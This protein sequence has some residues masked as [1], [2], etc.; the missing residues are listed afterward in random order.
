MY[1]SLLFTHVLYGSYIYIVEGKRSLVVL[2]LVVAII[3]NSK[4]PQSQMDFVW[5]WEGYKTAN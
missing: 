3:T 1:S 5:G 2:N 4:L